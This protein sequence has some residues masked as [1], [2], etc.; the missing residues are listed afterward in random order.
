[1]SQRDLKIDSSMGRSP[2][3]LFVTKRHGHWTFVTKRVSS[4]SIS[5]HSWDAWK[6]CLAGCESHDLSQY[7]FDILLGKYSKT[8]LTKITASSKLDETTIL[9]DIESRIGQ[10]EEKL[11]KKDEIMRLLEK[12]EEL[13]ETLEKISGC[14]K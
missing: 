10:D 12:R 8:A 5:P 14:R 4:S 13:T 3:A 11:K 1:M 2:A 9:K 7:L 6:D